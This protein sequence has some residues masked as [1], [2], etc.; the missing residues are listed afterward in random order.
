MII[1]IG[2]SAEVFDENPLITRTV[3]GVLFILESQII[4]TPRRYFFTVVEI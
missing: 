2:K 4:N 1:P 3:N